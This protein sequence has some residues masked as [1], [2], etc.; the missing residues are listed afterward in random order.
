MLLVWRVF[1]GTAIWPGIEKIR[2]YLQETMEK[3]VQ[4]INGKKELNKKTKKTKISNWVKNHEQYKG[5]IGNPIAQF[6]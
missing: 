1:E 5:A 4:R 2:K 3:H 6:L